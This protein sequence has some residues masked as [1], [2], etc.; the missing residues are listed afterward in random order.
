MADR[1]SMLAHF[2]ESARLAVLAQFTDFAA[3][4]ATPAPAAAQDLPDRTATGW[5]FAAWTGLG[6]NDPQ[7]EAV[8]EATLCDPKYQTFPAFSYL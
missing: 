6:A 8:S 4:P 7:F 2:P 5:V 1:T 3:A